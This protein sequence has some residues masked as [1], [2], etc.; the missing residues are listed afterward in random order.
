MRSLGD[1][2][3]NGLIDIQSKNPFDLRRVNSVEKAM[4][5]DQE[6]FESIKTDLNY[7]INS[8]L[9]GELTG[10]QVGDIITTTSSRNSGR[11]IG[12]ITQVDE[13][14]MPSKVIHAAWRGVAETPFQ[15][16]GIEARDYRGRDRYDG[17]LSENCT[18]NYII[19]PRGGAL[20]SASR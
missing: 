6:H 4:V 3:L 10:C 20:M 14:G 1:L 12:I 11:H 5:S 7:S 9:R 18:I 19:R 16:S 17:F 2:G 13:R 15:S 8:G